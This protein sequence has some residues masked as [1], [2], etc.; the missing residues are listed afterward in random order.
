VPLNHAAFDGHFFRTLERSRK[1]QV[2]AA[3]PLLTWVALE[4]PAP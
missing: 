1:S 2:T 4:R 3:I